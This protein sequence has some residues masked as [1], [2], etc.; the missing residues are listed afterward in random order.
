MLTFRVRDIGKLMQV[1]IE[2]DGIPLTEFQMP[3]DAWNTFLL[4]LKPSQSLELI[5][6]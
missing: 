3:H 2:W 5:E 4:L 1:A 6:E